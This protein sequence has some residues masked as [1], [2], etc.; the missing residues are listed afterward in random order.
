MEI[1]Y[2]CYNT[3]RIFLFSV[4]TSE[5]SSVG[6]IIVQISASDDDIGHNGK[7]T[8]KLVSGNQQGNMR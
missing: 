1:R 5:S 7:L 8:Y 2:I 3:S 6:T 4:Q